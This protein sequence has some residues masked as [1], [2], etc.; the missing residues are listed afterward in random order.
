MSDP[1]TIGPWKWDGDELFSEHGFAVITAGTAKN[2][3]PYVSM[4]SA[5]RAIVAAAPD[6]AEAL[7]GILD[8]AE[9]AQRHP[10]EF[11]AHGVKNLM[12]PAFDKAVAAL[13]RAR[14]E[15]Q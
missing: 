3:C 7:Q 15:A 12:G 11:N 13:A 9:F 4:N 1:W 10:E 6:M 14:G 2:G 8:W 5:D